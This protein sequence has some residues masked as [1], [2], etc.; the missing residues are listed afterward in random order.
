M[1]LPDLVKRD[2]R[3]MIEAFLRLGEL[4]GKHGLKLPVHMKAINGNG[5]CFWHIV[6]KQSATGWD[7]DVLEERV[8]EKAGPLPMFFVAEDCKGKKI[9]VRF[10]LDDQVVQ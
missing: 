5:E 10:Q 8:V 4:C 9:R 3:P 7:G 2:G 1:S 6:L